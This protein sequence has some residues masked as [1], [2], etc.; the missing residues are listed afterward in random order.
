MAVIDAE[1]RWSLPGAPRRAGLDWDY[2]SKGSAR[3]SLTLDPARAFM[4]QVREAARP[5]GPVEVVFPV[6]HG[7]NGEDGTVQGFLELA[8]LPYVGCGVLGSALCMDK[9][10]AKRLAADAGVPILPYAALRAGAGA[11]RLA[12]RYARRLG[13]PVFVKPARLG[14]SVG[15]S[16]VTGPAALAGALREAFRFDDKILVEKGIEARE[17]EVAVLGET[18]QAQASPCGEIRPRAEFYDYKAKYLDPEGAELLVPAPLGRGTSERARAWAVRVFAA[19]DCHGM[20]RVDFLL[21]RRSGRLYFNEV[22]TIPGF[23]AVSLYPRMWAAAGL[24][25]PRL[26]DRLIALALARHKRRSALKTMR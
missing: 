8:G 13:W 24:P 2:P 4:P 26:L 9:E 18:A 16:K 7:P 3:R 22:N 10:L 14:S 19:L 6:L 21:D 15:I 12:A 5:S 23:T 17:I 25:F 20:A 1:G 11:P